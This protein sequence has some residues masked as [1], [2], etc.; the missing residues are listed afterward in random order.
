M[1]LQGR[2]VLVTGASRGIGSAI[3]LACARAG[4]HIGIGYRSNADAAQR[5]LDAV[6][7]LGGSAT[8]HCFDVRDRAAV[9]AGVARF[10]AERGRLD[11]LVNNAGVAGDAFAFTMSVENWNRVLEV[12]LTGPFHCARAAAA[13][14]MRSR[15]GCIINIAS[16]AG[17]R[18]SPGQANYSAAKGGLLAVTRTLAAELGRYGVRVNAVVPG[19]IAA[20][21][22]ERMDPR[23]VARRTEQ[24][25]LGR[26]GRAEEVAG[27]VAFM[28]SDAAAYITGQAIIV[29]GGWSM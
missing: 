17:V 25:P 14:M 8:L 13:A 4:A 24:I 28:A 7:A 2:T 12:D 18:A 3:A 21:M 16:V 15:S 11:V 10:A 22:V 29:D 26:L 23:V 19:M 20:G 5:T 27:V 6:V 1:P 9:D